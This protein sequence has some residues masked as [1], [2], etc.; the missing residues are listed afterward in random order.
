MQTARRSPGVTRW[1]G[2][3]TVT[4]E[5]MHVDEATGFNTAEPFSRSWANPTDRFVLFKSARH[6]KYGEP[7]FS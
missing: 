7:E 3:G 2:R 1:I 5:S 6:F 4:N